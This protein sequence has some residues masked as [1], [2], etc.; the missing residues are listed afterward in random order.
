MTALLRV[1]TKGDIAEVVRRMSEDWPEPADEDLV[2][3]IWS[4]P[5]F[6]LEN[7]ARL[8]D[9]SYVDVESQGEGRVWIDLRGRPSTEIIDWAEARAREKG[10]RLFAGGWSSN[11]PLLGDLEQR[12]FRLIRHSHRMMID[13]DDPTPAPLWPKDV[14][15]RSFRPGDERAFYE[16]HQE[17]FADSWE[18]IEEPY[19]EW[20]HW[21]L[22]PPAFVPELWFLAV[23]DGEPAGFAIC[24]PHAGDAECGWVRIL[25]V[26]RQW[27]RRGLGR[28]LLLHSFAEFRRRGLRRAGLGVDAESLTGANRLYEEAGMHVSARFDIYEKMVA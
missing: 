9:A 10:R 28:A 24:H 15:V 21:L 11:E 16:A 7:D 20:S 4:S 25:G 6:E 12:G 23:E 26:R 8:D 14:E 2:R 17:T 19:D 27:R 5:S 1:P 18:P 3:R 13:L 22:E